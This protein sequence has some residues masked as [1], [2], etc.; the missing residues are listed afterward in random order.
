[1]A[2]K[3]PLY[4]F[5][6]GYS[7]QDKVSF[8]MPG[9]KES[10]L[11]EKYGYGDF[12]K[13]LINYDITEV[14]GA[15]NLHGA[16]G[17][18]REGQERY[19]KLYGVQDSFYLVNGTTAGILA[20]I[21]SSVKKGGQLIMA[22]DCHKSVFNALRLGDIHPVYVYPEIIE[23]FN[24]SGVIQP[25]DIK[26]ALIT[27]PQAE[28]VILPRPNYYGICSDVRAIADMVHQYD[29]I[30]I[31]DEAHGAHLKFSKRLPDSAVDAGAD[32]VINSIH[33]TLASFTQSAVLHVNSNRVDTDALKDKLQMMQ[34]TSPSYLLMASLDISA[35]IIEEDGAQ[36]MN[37][38][39]EH[40]G[41]FKERLNGV[42][43]IKLMASENLNSDFDLTKLNI[44]MTMLGLTGRRVEGLLRE[45]FNIYMEM[46]STNLV[47]GLCGI[48]N[49][50]SDFARLSY[51]LSEI[52][53]QYVSDPIDN[54]SKIYYEHLE[55][56][57]VFNHIFERNRKW[58][59]LENS[60]GRVCTSSIIPYPPG[61]PMICPGERISKETAE[62]LHAL[63]KTKVKILGLNN[64]GEIQVV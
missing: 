36:L 58:V 18:I 50:E 64:C 49:K 41:N 30:L 26:K 6:I 4:D 33:K 61:I 2:V 9:H 3:S 48:G 56:A 11:Y 47:M 14:A 45:E 37:A 7:K 42:N 35:S 39:V 29:K 51:A 40:I 25:E 10:D 12:L 31:V 24:I 1:M 34:S 38:L 17:I 59:S 43:G 27:H 13:H 21:L 52:A 16:E 46:V 8:H 55:Q 54:F 19:A 44:D 20:A 28:A 23:D 15:D 32:I 5:L 60:A 22:R 62:Y 57:D 63:H 53:C